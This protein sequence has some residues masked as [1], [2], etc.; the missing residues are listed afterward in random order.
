[1]LRAVYA[2]H[3][4]GIVNGVRHHGHAV[5]HGVFDDVGQVKLLL[6]VA[7]VQPCQPAL[8]QFGGRGENAAVDFRDGQLLGR[9]VFLFDD[10]C[11]LPRRIAQHAA[12]AKGVGH[13]QGQQGQ[14]A[15]CALR[16][17]LLNGVGLR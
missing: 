12:I 9:A 4:H 13:V 16:D 3:L 15:A 11:D 10:A 8:E 6:G 7:V 1:M 2:G 5:C 17:Q 14:L